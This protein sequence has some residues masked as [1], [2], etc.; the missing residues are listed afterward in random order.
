MQRATIFIDF[1]FQAE[2]GMPLKLIEIG[3]VRIYSG[4]VATFSSLIRQ[5]GI[6]QDV[7][8]LTGIQR[9][10][11]Q[12]APLYKEVSEQFLAF[13]GQAPIFI[14]FSAQDREIFYA[15]RFWEP[16]LATSK[17]IDYQ[18][19]LMVHHNEQRKPSLTTLLERYNIQQHIA[20]RALA[21]A[22][23]LH[24]LYKA[25]GGEALIAAQR[26]TTIFAPFVRR[27]MKNYVETIQVT[28]YEYDMKTSAKLLHEWQF[29]VPQQQVEVEVELAHSGLLG[30]MKHSVTETQYI[31]GHNDASEAALTAINEL[32]QGALLFSPTERCGLAN[33]FLDYG[34]PMTK[35]T[36]LPYYVLDGYVY[37][38]EQ[39]ERIAK[40]LRAVR[41]GTIATYAS[42][43]DVLQAHEEKITHY[44][45]QIAVYDV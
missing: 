34:V 23:A 37:S 45:Q 21:D 9:Q 19:K 17:F 20:H 38:K 42:I 1:E 4:E 7:L 11:L 24:A 13:V 28:L 33:V 10:E 5:K 41:N 3:A 29:D 31:Y 6:Q 27:T 22:H 43:Y 16:L 40:L 15:N 30:M 12:S 36:M 44:L 25:S 35:C 8:T 39:T 18:E 2:R 14:F 32:I 26:T